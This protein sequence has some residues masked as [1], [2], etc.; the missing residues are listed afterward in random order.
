MFSWNLI[1]RAARSLEVESAH[2]DNHQD[3]I[4]GQNLRRIRWETQTLEPLKKNFYV[5]HPKCANRPPQEIIAYF[6][7]CIV[8][9]LMII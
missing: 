1:A 4:P 8:K 6:Q 3:W 2:F 9:V 5:E 7:V